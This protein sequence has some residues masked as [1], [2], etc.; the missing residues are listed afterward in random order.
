MK[1]KTNKEFSRMLR[2]ARLDHGIGLRKLA[3]RAKIHFSYLSQ[4]E[5]AEQPP[6][7]L[8][9][10]LR[11]AEELQSKKLRDWGFLIVRA[12]ISD[13]KADALK[14]CDSVERFGETDA[15]REMRRKLDEAFKGVSIVI[16]D[17]PW[18]EPATSMSSGSSNRVSKKR[19][20]KV[21]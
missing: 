21:K 9:T 20:R 16:G 6:P 11:L 10:L 7:A 18:G 5:R 13:V 14:V 2:K 19:V 4:L 17:P 8:E 15:A 12:E 1:K 3:L